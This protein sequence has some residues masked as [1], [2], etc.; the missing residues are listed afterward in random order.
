MLHLQ[1]ILYLH[2]KERLC[3]LILMMVLHFEVLS[4]TQ[5][6]I[7]CS[8]KPRHPLQS[9]QILALYLQVK[10]FILENN[11]CRDQKKGLLSRQKALS[12]VMAKNSLKTDLE[13]LTITIIIIIVR[14]QRLNFPHRQILANLKTITKI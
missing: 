2:S 4:L 14:S 5:L 8:F 12:A 10:S 3:I 6:N 13:T 7:S 11:L 9:G 1:D